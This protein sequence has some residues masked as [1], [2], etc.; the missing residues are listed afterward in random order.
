MFIVSNVCVAHRIV[1]GPYE[2][3]ASHSHCSFIVE[4]FFF[5]SCA[6]DVD[7]SCCVV[8]ETDRES[9]QWEREKNA[10]P[11][12]VDDFCVN[13]FSWKFQSKRKFTASLIR[14]S[15]KLLAF[16]LFSHFATQIVADVF[17]YNFFFSFALPFF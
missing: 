7:C 1:I 12:S 13:Y 6:V 15:Y 14:K 3:P 8:S 16:D 10:R 5:L 11:F 2:N 9:K 17:R 4:V